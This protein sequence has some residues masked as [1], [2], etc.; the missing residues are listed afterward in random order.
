MKIYLTQILFRLLF[1]VVL[2]MQE[3]DVLVRGWEPIS[4]F[5]EP[6]VSEAFN[7]LA[8]LVGSKL[9]GRAHVLVRLPTEP[10]N[11]LPNEN[12]RIHDNLI[13]MRL[14]LIQGVAIGDGELGKHQVEIPVRLKRARFLLRQLDH[15]PLVHKL[16]SPILEPVYINRIL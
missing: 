6:V 13:E 10:I 15:C 12:V 16:R 14:N 7:G 3:S 4:A 11:T 9:S 8:H 5:L 2:D 1:D